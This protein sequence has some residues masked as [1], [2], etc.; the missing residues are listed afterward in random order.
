MR[1]WPTAPGLVGG[2]VH[3]GSP[4]VQY[5]APGAAAVPD[6]FALLE[7]A[8]DV[9]P[10]DYAQT[11]VR[12]VVERSELDRPLIVSAVVRPAWLAAVAAEPGVGEADLTDALAEYASQGETA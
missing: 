3:P 1:S 11:Y 8:R 2:G 12:F 6:P 7:L 10:P 4:S 5:P 9:R